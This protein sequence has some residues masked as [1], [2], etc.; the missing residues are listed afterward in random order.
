[1]I[2]RDR[3]QPPKG[4]APPGR[5]LQRRDPAIGEWP[6]SLDEPQ[7]REAGREIGRTFMLKD[8]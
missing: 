8:R 6:L 3:G 7:G 2:S 5:E 1:V 4:H